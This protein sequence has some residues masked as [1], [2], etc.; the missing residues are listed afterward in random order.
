MKSNNLR[1]DRLKAMLALEE[2]RASVQLELDNLTAKLANLKDTLFDASAEAPAADKVRK[3]GPGQKAAPAAKKTATGRGNTAKG[4]LREKV[5]AALEAAGSEGV[6]VKDLAQVLGTK[7]V[8]IHSWFHSN[9]QR[10]PSIQKL[11]GGHYRLVSGAKTDTVKAAKATKVAKA[12]KAPKAPKAGK[13]PK[14]AKAPK[15]ASG[16]KTGSKRGALATQILSTLEDAGAAGMSVRDIA[17]KLDAK[18]K[19]IYIWFATTGKKNP[20]IKKVAKATY[21]LNN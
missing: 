15:T 14:A 9:I 8:N 12:P 21:S 1:I 13:A 6:Y 3:T 19:N 10:N 18:Y 4:S 20:S 2:R 7:P 11:T 17:A 5:L 16:P